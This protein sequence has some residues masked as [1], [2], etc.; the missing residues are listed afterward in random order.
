MGTDCWIRVC[1]AIFH[2]KYFSARESLIF[3]KKIQRS[4]RKSHPIV[5]KRMDCFASCDLKDLN[6]QTSFFY[7]NWNKNSRTVCLVRIVVYKNY[8]TQ[9]IFRVVMSLNNLAK[10]RICMEQFFYYLFSSAIS[11]FMF[12][13]DLCRCFF[14]S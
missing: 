2:C 4:G 1:N 3:R 6:K 5:S 12:R 11:K 7:L 13:S 8:I 14:V 9:R 10:D